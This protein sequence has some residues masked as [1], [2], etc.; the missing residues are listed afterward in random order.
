MLKTLSIAVL[1]LFVC[2]AADAAPDTVINAYAL[3][4]AY[5]PCNQLTVDSATGFNPGDDILIIQHKGV[6]FDSSNTA[7]FGQVSNWND[8]GNYELNTIQSVSGNI[9]TL[10]YALTRTY[11]MTNGNVQVVKVPH[12]PSYTV[13]TRH[14]CRPWDGSKG[15]IF[16]IRVDNVLT[17]NNNIDVSGKGLRAGI[18]DSPIYHTQYQFHQ[19]DYSYPA[20]LYKGAN[21]GEGICYVSQS[22]IRCRGPLYNGGG[23]G[24]STNAGGG[25]GGNGGAGGIGGNEWVGAGTPNNYGGLGGYPFTYSQASNRIYLAGAGGAGDENDITHA[26]G[27]NGGGL[28]FIIA[29]S[30][31]GNGDSVIAD[32]TGGLSC[33]CQ[34]AVG[35]AGA[36]GTILINAQSVSNLKAMLRGGHGADVHTTVGAHGPGGG[37]GGGALLVNTATVL[38][39]ITYSVNGGP[40]GMYYNGNNPAVAWGAGDG[41]IGVTV[42]DFVAVVDTAA[43]APFNITISDSLTGCKEVKLTAYG[44]NPSLQYQWYFGD[45]TSGNGNPVSHIYSQNGTYQVMLV[46]GVPGCSDTVYYPVTVNSGTSYSISD[47]AIGCQSIQLSA[48][49]ISGSQGTQFTWLYGDASPSGNGNPVTHHYMQ[50]GTY[51]VTLIVAD[52]TGCSDTVSRMVTLTSGMNYNIIDSVINCKTIMLSADY[53]SGDTATQFLWLFSDN[54]TTPGDPVT[55]IYNQ[56]GSYTVSLILSNNQGCTDTVLHSFTLPVDIQYDITDSGIDCKTAQLRANYISGDTAAQLLWLFANNETEATNPA[57]HTFPNTGQNNARLVLINAL[58]CRDTV[59]YN[60]TINYQLFA[61]F[62]FTPPTAERN[63]PTQFYNT[64][65]PKAVTFHWN[66][67]DSTSS[68][69]ENPLKQYSLS[70]HY[71]VCLTATDVNGCS[72]TVC[73]DIA[74]DIVEL[75]DVP[76]A[77]SPNGDGKN[78]I[79]F[80]RGFGVKTMSLSIYNRWGQKIFTST[81]LKTGWDGTYKGV[82]QP[83]EVYGYIL[84]AVFESGKTYHKQGNVTVLR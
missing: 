22:K 9:I 53:A 35:G 81:D 68:D 70:G 11:D 25:G 67:G 78:D 32:G 77:F 74:A 8:A 72:A 15:G 55:H 26:D 16:A 17:L 33:N 62:T 34:D 51:T 36:G 46:A 76:D 60:F 31:A 69:E 47:S 44:S 52:A 1:L 80:A 71:I 65:S 21:K 13:N 79:L 45:N 37:G 42:P 43:F 83:A 54:T 28:V 48:N 2:N 39:S 4:T 73:K 27:G 57:I 84:D 56:N 10:N 18:T 6:F 29:G 82:A 20:N 24:N 38:A 3:A 12:F 19:P 49:H 63:I 59:N 30:I 23:G 5:S 14:S 58:G 50:N 7:S 40:Q 66:F 75:I 61:D 64:S 41:D